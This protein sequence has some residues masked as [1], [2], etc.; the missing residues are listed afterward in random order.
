M[1][2]WKKS[3]GSAGKDFR[4][5]KVWQKAHPLTL[6]VDQLTAGFPREEL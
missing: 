6:A 1:E 3:V 2:S 4:A 5:L